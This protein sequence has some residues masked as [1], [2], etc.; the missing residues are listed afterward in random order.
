MRDVPRALR[1]VVTTVGMLAPAGVRVLLRGRE[2]GLPHLYRQIGLLSM[3]LGPAFVKAG[4]VLGTRRDILPPALCS[5]LEVLQD[6]VPPLDRARSEEV[7]RGIYGPRLPELFPTIDYEPIAG[8]SVACVYR[9]TDHEGREVAL[10]VLRPEIRPV[11]EADLRI[12]RRG[13]RL[14]ARLPVLRGVPVTDVVD[15]MCAAV[16]AQLD[17][18]RE[19]D[20]LTRLRRDL[21]AVPRVWVPTVYPEL[22]GPAC[23]AMEFIP[24]LDVRTAH[25]CPPAL[26]RRFAQSALAA[27]YHMLFVDGFVHCDLHPGNLY[28]TRGGDV[29]VL[30][31][32]FSVQLTERLRVLFAE[33]FLNMAV[34]RGDRCAEIVVA[35]STGRRP[36]ADLPGFLTRMAE[37][38]VRVHGLSAREFSL[39]GFATEMF[40]LQRRHGVHAAPELIFPLLSLL[41]IEG[42]IRELDPDADFQETA[43]PVLNRGLFGARRPT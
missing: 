33:F 41:V 4:Q 27:I 11:L 37:L 21:S 12:M 8:G 10:K 22:C 16:L 23:V 20:N 32:G 36:D 25:R 31:A 26:R 24:D 6:A 35:S 34:G 7:L 28:F 18:P 15:A 43:K 2:R 5:E 1:V 17:F 38:V 42:T 29:V 9:A 39:I 40:D 13:A 14:A 3:A 19:A 30:D